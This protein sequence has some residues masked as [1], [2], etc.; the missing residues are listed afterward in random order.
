M[1]HGIMRVRIHGKEYQM[2][3]RTRKIS[4]FTRSLK[5]NQVT[6]RKKKNQTSDFTLR[7]GM[8]RKEYH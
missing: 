4:A 3:Q 8:Q 1:C 2:S 5:Y 7:V 6:T